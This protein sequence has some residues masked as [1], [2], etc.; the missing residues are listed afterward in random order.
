V[1][2]SPDGG[3]VYVTNIGSNTVSVIQRDTP[4]IA[5]GAVV[6][7]I[8]VGPGPWGVAVAPDGGHAYVTNTAETKQGS[9][10]ANTVS[11]IDTATHTVVTTLPPAGKHPLGVVATAHSVYVA[12]VGS[13]VVSVIDV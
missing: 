4:S 11:V 6:N 12:H 7:T 10:M 13:D 3:H 2:V 9:P 5:P 1:A 8:P